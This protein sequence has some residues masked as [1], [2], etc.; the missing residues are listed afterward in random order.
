MQV[1]GNLMDFLVTEEF[2]RPL[3]QWWWVAGGIT[4]AWIFLSPFWSMGV[5]PVT[6][7]TFLDWGAVHTFL[8]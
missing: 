5:S 7:G 1:L 4:S 2:L 3:G 6:T 8:E